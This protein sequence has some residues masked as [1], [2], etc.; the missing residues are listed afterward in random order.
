MG[1]AVIPFAFAGRIGIDF[2]IFEFDFGLFWDLDLGVD[3]PFTWDRRF[4]VDRAGDCS[5]CLR[6]LEVFLDLF[7]A[8]SLCPRLD[9]LGNIFDC[10]LF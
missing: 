5:N 6:T 2:G 3:L 10:Y 9:E 4:A 8:N 1:A 7:G